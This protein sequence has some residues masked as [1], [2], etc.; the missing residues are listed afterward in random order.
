[1]AG[2]SGISVRSRGA[3]GAQRV[4][5]HEGVEPVVLVPGGAVA[6]AQAVH[7]VRADHHHRQPGREQGVDHQAVAAFDGHLVHAVAAQPADELAQPG[8]GRGNGEPIDRG[9]LVVHHRDGVIADGPVH[10]GGDPAQGNSVRAIGTA[11]EMSTGAC[12]MCASV[13]LVR[14]APVAGVRVAAPASL[15]VRR[16]DGA[17]PL[18][19]VRATQ[20]TTRPRI[21]KGGRRVRVG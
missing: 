10:A 4:G 9:A 2:V 6:A 15:T 19:T 16:S 14:Q 12:A 1:V 8:A 11:V 21:S 13:V 7:L 20:V 3:V 5:Q 17:Q 18:S